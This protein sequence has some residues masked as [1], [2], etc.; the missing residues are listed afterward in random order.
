MPVSGLK[1]ARAERLGGEISCSK[2]RAM[3]RVATA[4]TC[5]R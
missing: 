2:I 4:L 5:H 3:T 1:D